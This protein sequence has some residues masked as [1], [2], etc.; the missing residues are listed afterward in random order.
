MRQYIKTIL[1]ISAL[2]VVPILFYSYQQLKSLSE[3][4]KMAEQIYQRQ[5]ETV[6]FSL[7][8]YADDMMSQWARRLGS[9]E[10][11]IQ[12]NAEKLMLRNEPIQVLS[13]QKWSGKEDTLFYGDYVK[14]NDSIAWAIKNWRARHDSTLQRLAEYSVAGFQKIQSADGWQDQPYLQGFEVPLTFMLTDQDSSLYNAFLILQTQFW[15]EQILGAKIQ[16]LAIDGLNVA[17]YGGTEPSLIYA[18]DNYTA[19]KEYVETA[20]WILPSIQLRIQTAGENYAS[21]VKK[22][23]EDNL[24][25]LLITLAILLVGLFLLYRSTRRTLQLAQLKSDFVSNVSHEIRTPLSLIRMY[26]ETLM[27]GRVV[28][29]DRQKQ[30]YKVIYHE[31]GRLTHL[32][33]NILDFSRIE[34]NKKTY[35]FQKLLPNE[36]IHKILDRYEHTFQEHHVQ[37]HLDLEASSSL[38]YGDEEALSEVISNL[39]DNAIKYNDKEITEIGIEGSFLTNKF[40]LNIA[41]NGPGIPKKE[42]N[43]VFERFYR[44]ENALTQQTKG[45][46]MGLSLV[47]HI[48]TAHKASIQLKQN[49]PTGLIF[50][51]VFPLIT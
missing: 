26:A 9:S 10:G 15:T 1:L 43:K 14:E 4:E 40:V 5:M 24:V 3:D 51:I 13:I 29:E 42:Y 34:A 18:S 8:Q 2:V 37:L 22:R 44:I 20:L 39:I 50:E 11:S 16:E 25:F 19:G 21:L 47:K 17:V 33:N 35:H 27:L 48:L 45:T 46:G 30:Y 49:K 36:L 38:I 31:A 6:L 41:D 32:V 23:S 12:K 7:N 28:K